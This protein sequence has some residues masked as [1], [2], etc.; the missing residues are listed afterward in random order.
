MLL[1]AVLAAAVTISGAGSAAGERPCLQPLDHLQDLKSHD[2]VDEITRTRV[3]NL[4]EDARQ[5]CGRG[6]QRTPR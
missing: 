2:A 6:A 5:L 4:V 1:P 3:E